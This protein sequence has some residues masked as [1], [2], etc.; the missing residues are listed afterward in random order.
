MDRMA[1]KIDDWWERRQARRQKANLKAMSTA[2][3]QAEIE[4]INAEVIADPR[5]VNLSRFTPEEKAEWFADHKHQY[6]R[7]KDIE[8]EL[9]A[10][11]AAESKGRGIA[12]LEKL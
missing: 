3:L 4:K 6:D 7:T 10:R 5:T 2:E 8:A 1:G 9:A 11:A 12:G